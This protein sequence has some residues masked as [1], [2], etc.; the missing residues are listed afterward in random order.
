[1]L[2]SERLVAFACA[3][4]NHLNNQFAANTSLVTKVSVWIAALA[5]AKDKYVACPLCT[6]IRLL[7]NKNTRKIE[8]L[9]A[10]EM[11]VVT[12]HTS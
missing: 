3:T 4:I 8:N 1:M 2:A 12:H 6:A 7:W 5:S 11:A 10:G 9:V